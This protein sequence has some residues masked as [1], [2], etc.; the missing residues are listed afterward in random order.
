MPTESMTIAECRGVLRPRMRELYRHGELSL[1]K[2]DLLDGG[3]PDLR[4]EA[5]Q[6]RA[7]ARRLIAEA[8]AI[9][10]MMRCMRKLRAASAV[11]TKGEVG[12]VGDASATTAAGKDALLLEVLRRHE[13]DGEVSVSMETMSREINATT[14]QTRRRLGRLALAGW[15]EARMP[16]R[17][18]P[19]PRYVLRQQRCVRYRER[20][21]A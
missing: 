20:S 14:S 6:L 9:Y 5:S 4:R 11:R 19:G 8:D 18:D 13:K 16:K 15:I 2:A 10:W 7:E 21:A 12:D 17:G 3:D 1:R